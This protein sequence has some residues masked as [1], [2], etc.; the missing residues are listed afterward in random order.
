MKP[1][2]I[3]VLNAPSYPALAKETITKRKPDWLRIKL[4]SGETFGDVAGLLSDLKL[5]TVCKSAHCPNIGECWGR[6]TATFMILGDI[7]TRGCR[8]CAIS[9]GKPEPVDEDEP[10]RLAEAAKAMNLHWIVITS[11]DRDDLPD[12]GAGHFVKV[13][14][15]VRNVLPEAGIETL[16][17]D[18][19]GKPDAVEIICSEPPNV[20]NHN[21]ETVP[22]LYRRVRPGARYDHSLWLIKQFSDAGL[23]TKSGL[24]VGVGESMDEVRAVIND[25]REHGCRSLT[26]G[27][28]LAPSGN[29]LEVVRFVHPNEFKELEEYAYRI[30]FDHVASGPL[31]RSSYK[32]EQAMDVYGMKV[33]R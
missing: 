16:V 30:G 7:C 23:I 17:P 4:N 26:I 32:A 5:N 8:F 10:R 27:Q 24:M 13:I 21:I 14:S 3:K 9:T 2:P 15:A 25:L 19:R 20:L 1:L 12:G 22:R 11:V 28:Y 29:H 6:G 33:W 18:F 31:V